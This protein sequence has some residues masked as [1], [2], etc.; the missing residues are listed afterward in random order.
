M[1]FTIDT[2]FSEENSHVD[3]SVTSKKLGTAVSIQNVAYRDGNVYA[4]AYSPQLPDEHFIAVLGTAKTDEERKESILASIKDKE[5]KYQPSLVEDMV[6]LVEVT[7]PMIRP[8][9]IS[10]LFPEGI[11]TRFKAVYFVAL[12]ITIS[13]K[14]DKY[15]PTGYVYPLK[16][17]SL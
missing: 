14:G 17:L 9:E 3:V 10:K 12:P 8:E 16:P 13:D 11:S 6:L 15:G 1:D 5:G 2:S 7:I 4:R